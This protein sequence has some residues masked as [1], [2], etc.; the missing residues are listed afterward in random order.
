[1]YED[2]ELSVESQRE[3]A[4]VRLNCEATV[5]MN[6]LRYYEDAED[7][8]LLSYRRGDRR[9]EP[10]GKFKV[11]YSVFFLRAQKLGIYFEIPEQ[12][13]SLAETTKIL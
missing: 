4:T 6:R 12:W 10:H 8:I 2:A 5:A 7:R 3:G 1:M 13:A 9:I 11:R